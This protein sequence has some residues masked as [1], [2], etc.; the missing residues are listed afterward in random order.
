LSLDGILSDILT[1]RENRPL[2]KTYASGKN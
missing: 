2:D 1:E